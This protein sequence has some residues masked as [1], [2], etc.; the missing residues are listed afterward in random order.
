MSIIGYAEVSVYLKIEFEMKDMGEN[1][2]LLGPTDRAS[3]NR[4]ICTPVDLL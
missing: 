3:P 2:V 4:N 1:Q